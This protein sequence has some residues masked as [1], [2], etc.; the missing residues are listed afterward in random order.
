MNHQPLEPLVHFVFIYYMAIHPGLRSIRIT[1]EQLATLKSLNGR[2]LIH[3]ACELTD[4]LNMEE[5]IEH[6][7]WI[8]S[9]LCWQF[10]S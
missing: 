4:Y 9:K 6:L 1:P 5:K 10:C 3:Y 8:V 7:D 2:Q